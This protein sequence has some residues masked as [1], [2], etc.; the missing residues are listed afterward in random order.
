MPAKLTRFIPIVPLLMLVALACTCGTPDAPAEQIV[1]SNESAQELVEKIGAIETG[2]FTLV[3]TEQELTSAAAI[4]L[5]NQTS[6]PITDPQIYLR[7]NSIQLYAT[8]T[9]EGVSS[10]LYIKWTVAVNAEGRAEL[11]TVDATLGG[12]PVPD[13][14]LS[15]I[16][17]EIDNQL[18]SAPEMNQVTLTAI[19]I[20]DGEA[21]ITGTRNQ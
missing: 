4:A 18:M 16:N 19:E 8:G 12:F 13:S 3:V 15:Q 6:I 21:T 20:G 11:T 14:L 1:V 10:A 9:M 17:N 5:E 7:D 2:E